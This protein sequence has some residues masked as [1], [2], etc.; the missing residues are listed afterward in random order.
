M[1][2]PSLSE[3]PDIVVG[4]IEAGDYLPDMPEI[5]VP[6]M[7]GK[8]LGNPQIDWSFVTVPQSAANDRQIF[9]PRCVHFLLPLPFK[10]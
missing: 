6:G 4:V 10:H 2:S 8:S 9:E 1:S 3:D 7:V 5:N